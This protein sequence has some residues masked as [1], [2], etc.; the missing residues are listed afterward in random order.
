MRGTL[1][2]PGD[3]SHLPPLRHAG[4]DR[5]AARRRSPIW[6]RAPTSP[7]TV[8]C[9]RG[10]GVR[11]DA[12][13]SARPRRPRARAGPACAA[14]AGAARR[15]Q[16]RARR[17]ACWPASWPAGRSGPRSPATSRSRRR[18]DAPRHRPADRDGRPHRLATTAAR[19]SSSTAAR[20]TADRLA[21][22][23]SPAPRSRAPSCSPASPPTG[24]TSVIEPLATRDHTERAFPAF[25][26]ERRRVGRADGVASTGGQEAT[27]AGRP[28]CACPATRRRRPSGRRR[29][30]RCPARRSDS[31]GV[32]LNPRRLGFVARA[33]AD[34]RATSRSRS[35][36]EVGGEPVGHARRARTAATRR[37]DDRAPTRCPSL[38]D[39]LPVLAARAALGGSLEVVGRR[40]A[41]RQGKRPDHRARRRASARSA[42]TPTSGPTASSSTARGSR[43]A[44]PAMRRAITG[45]SW[46]SRSSALGAAGPTRDHRRRRGGGVL[47]GLRAGPGAA[48]ARDDRQDLSRRLHGQRQEH[49]RARAGAA[50]AAGAP[51]TSTT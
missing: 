38:I 49:D 10:L 31:T 37:R 50:A 44:A 42:S 24:T 3:K 14:P 26:L 34:G 32:C 20:C 46:P 4:R 9:L 48:D 2:C 28:L 29:P 43:R 36:G 40:R 13:G 21:H 5:R 22:R 25:G 30:R 35:T 41:A 18:P 39:E 15:R 19:R 7:S 27:R 23:R 16:L 51:R 8:A 17:C 47:S 33:R 45:W 11:I 6:R 12:P 1:A